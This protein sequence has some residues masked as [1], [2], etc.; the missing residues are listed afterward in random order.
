MRALVTGAT[1]FIG[2]RLVGKLARPVVLSRDPEAA[3]RSL[4]D[5]E[6]HRWDPGAGPPPEA[7]LDGV[8][9]IFHL[10]GESVAGRWTAARKERI[11]SSRVVGTRN[12]VAA[13]AARTARPAVLVSGSAVGYY[14]SRGD[15][16]IDESAPAG[17]DFLANVCVAWE[18]ESAAARA[19]GLRVVNPRVGV[20]LGEGGGALAR[21]LAP[22]RLGLGGRL[23]DGRQWMPWVHIDDLV[24][25]LL[26]AAATSA[27]DGPM[28]AVAPTPVTNRAFTRTLASVLGRPAFLPAPSFVLKAALGEFAGAL[29]G[30]LRAVPQVAERTGYR[31]RFPELEPALRD[32][33]VRPSAATVHATP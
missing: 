13:I 30:S 16:V 17:S 19:L 21:M 6:A 31:F 20:V 33:L 4:G 24:G 10:A 25:L 1:G 32:L 14:G 26:H 18:R 15:D 12:L 23:G 7:A 27:I 9:T 2:R 8:D 22:F 29:L 28:N 5:V 11:R 3:K